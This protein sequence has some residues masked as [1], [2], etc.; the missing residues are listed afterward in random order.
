[1]ARQKEPFAQRADERELGTIA[2]L[3]QG[4][5]RSYTV[6][7]LPVLNRLLERMNLEE[8][9]QS[10]LPRDDPRSKLPVAK[11][12][13]ALVK[14][15][16][17]SREPIYGLGE[18]AARYDPKFLGL[19]PQ[20]VLALNDD[21]AGRCLSIFFHGDRPQV[22][23]DVVGHVVRAFTLSL[24]ELHNDSTTVS[25]F[26]AYSDAAEEK[27]RRGQRTLAITWGHNK[28][29]RPD[30]KQLL[31]ILTISNDG[32]VP[33]HFRAASGNV[34]DDT[35]HQRSWELLCQI[36]GRRDFL[37]VADCKL[38]TIG[39]MNYIAHNG[40]RFVSVLPR[41]R[42]EDGAF[43]QRMLQKQIAWQPLWSKTDEKGEVIDRFSICDEATVLPE[44]YR[45]WWFHS[46]RKAEL[47]LAARSG[48]LARAEQQLRHLQEKFRSP[49]SRHRDRAKAH[50]QV[51]KILDHYQA[52]ECI[53]VEIAERQRETYHQRTPGRPGKDTLYVKE[54]SARLELDYTIDAQQVDRERQ[55]DGV[56]PL[57]TNDPE[58]SALQVL[59]AYKHQ[60]Q[61][62]KRFEQLKTDFAVAPVFLKDVG[63]IEAL[64]CLYFFVLLTESLLE[65]ELR[66]AMEREGLETLPLY[67]EGRPCRRPTARRLIDAF[68]PI[69]RHVFQNAQGR[70]TTVT[71]ELSPL[72]RKLLRLLDL[73]ATIYDC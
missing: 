71:T 12:L 10:H 2:R 47:D 44:G 34:T 29:H 4:T 51:A 18:W 53:R 7:A 72:Q 66:R 14:N 27:Q 49:R 64:F 37:Y 5:L 45:L 22:V 21:R 23:L 48:R 33:V 73:P 42:K 60:P 70:T 13:L 54:V 68:A 32:G 46:T 15:L 40:G 41:T 30:L 62:E 67:P 61:I 19:T 17:V 16:L 1:M 55:T 20:Q 24:D 6:G 58:L 8:I 65:R 39:N 25:F 56:F 69:Q 43:R 35:T 3:Q 57:V 63:R 50:E 26:G 59:L 52:A 11:G 9:L 31:Y 38:A 36:A 28:D